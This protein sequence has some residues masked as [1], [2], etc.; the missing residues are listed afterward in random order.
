MDR[1]LRARAWAFTLGACFL[2]LAPSMACSQLRSS[3]R[4]AALQEAYQ[5][6]DGTRLRELG[7]QEID[8]IGRLSTSDLGALLQSYLRA[9]NRRGV[10][11][12]EAPLV[13]LL[14]ELGARGDD[15]LRVIERNRRA[16]NKLNFGSQRGD[17]PNAYVAVSRPNSPVVH[18][19]PNQIVRSILDVQVRTGRLD[20]DAV[21]DND[22]C[23]EEG[24]AAFERRWGAAM[25]GQLRAVCAQ[26]GAGS[27]GPGGGVPLGG[28][29][30]LSVLD[31][32]LDRQPTRAERIS[33]L[34]Q[35][36]VASMELGG[37]G[38]PV[39]AGGRPSRSTHPS[40]W[41]LSDRT[42]GR[43]DD[44]HDGDGRL[45]SSTAWASDSPGSAALWRVDFN[46]DGSFKQTT[47]NENG[48]VA[49][50]DYYNANVE[51]TRTER[52]DSGGN[53]TY[54]RNNHSD[55]GWSET[56]NR[57]DGD[58]RLVSTSTSSYDKSAGAETTT[59]LTYTYDENG[60]R[61]ESGRSTYTA[62][63]PSSGSDNARTGEFGQ[64]PECRNMNIALAEARH[65]D[66]LE[67]GG[68]SPRPI[69]NPNPESDLTYVPAGDLS[70]LS[71]AGARQLDDALSCAR[72]A[73]CPPGALP[74]SDCGCR[75]VNPGAWRPQT[76]CSLTIN[77]ADGAEPTEVNGRCICQTSGVLAIDP[78]VRGGGVNPDPA[79]IPGLGV[80]DTIRLEPSLNREPRAP[81]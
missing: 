74:G 15:G 42:P 68:F 63:I 80:R 79:S 6:G 16:L 40:D 46:A 10:Q 13:T 24:L 77:C 11:G 34:M 69:V 54:E 47:Y 2:V 58:G 9:A 61:V 20:P 67:A 78:W 72:V 52:Y 31:C 22:I 45:V 37:G 43:V 28:T 26:S 25:A 19:L 55:G 73:S 18:Y 12:L 27:G 59:T 21:I 51:L 5:R 30:D 62:Q 7:F 3:D 48:G 38:D 36:C 41:G 50:V 23:S 39:A 66:S 33:S 29:A 65:N 60:N 8:S 14:A 53:L 1:V 17:R 71:M 49:D 35:S 81:R 75:P 64:T 32:L 4:S 57:Y 76:Q 56:T 44:L 70:C